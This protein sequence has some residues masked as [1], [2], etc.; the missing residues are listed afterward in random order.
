MSKNS[1]IEIFD[2]R[3]IDSLRWEDYKNGNA[4]KNYFA[5]LIKK[6]V[7][8]HI[9]NVNVEQVILVYGTELIP[10]SIAQQKKKPQAYVASNIGQYFD[11]PIEEFQRFDIVK[12]WKK[13]FSILSLR[14]L[15]KLSSAL[16][17]D[18]C[19]F[20]NSF[21]LSSNLCPKNYE[22]IPK[23]MTYL[24]NKYPDKC[25]VFKGVSPEYNEKLFIDL[26]RS[27]FKPVFSR[28]LYFISKTD[29]KYQKKRA[30]I[31]D[32]KHAEKRTDILWNSND[33]LDRNQ[34][35]QFLKFYEDLYIGKYSNLNPK[36]TNEFLNNIAEGGFFRIGSLKKK[37]NFLGAQV[38]FQRDGMITTPFIGYDRD[39]PQ[40]MGIYR[41]LNYYLMD[42]ANKS[43]LNLNLSSGA[44]E[45]KKQRGGV[46]G[47]EYNMVFVDHL[48][49]LRKL[50]W[51]ILGFIGR[52]FVIPNLSKVR[53]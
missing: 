6:G 34:K 20:I 52:R 46:S 48:H 39:L 50:P 7:K 21:L 35:S 30:F 38:L 15:R 44:A 9:E 2:S 28:E 31:R 29:V 12:G 53:L 36:Y 18:E 22:E 40:E 19:V 27:K 14:V 32:R 41:I 49:F 33:K 10:M 8:L 42:K 37:N 43:E 23:L 5:P 24:K 25:F 11:Y 51:I 1:K 13:A 26:S 17:I 3:N 45:F 16:K 4:F 47:I